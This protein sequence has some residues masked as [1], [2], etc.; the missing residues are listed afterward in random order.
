MSITDWTLSIK[1]HVT[2]PQNKIILEFGL[3]AGTKF[4]LDN[5]KYVYSY[6][7]AKDRKWYDICNT[8]YGSHPR[9]W[10]P[11][12]KQLQVFDGL[13]EKTLAIEKNRNTNRTCD[14]V[15]QL[16]S[17][18]CNQVNLD[19]VDVVLVDPG[20]YHR[21]ELASQ[22]MKRGVPIVVCHD[23][24]PVCRTLYGYDQ[25]KPEPGYELHIE[26]NGCWTAYFI[27]TL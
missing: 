19:T 15:N 24:L 9:L 14:G 23:F 26:D 1:K 4:L 13:L 3:G 27:R 21:A 6:E 16:V 22:M 2:D 11:M 5:F 7:C 25:L 10:K 12:F 18:L 8:E 17:D 20:F